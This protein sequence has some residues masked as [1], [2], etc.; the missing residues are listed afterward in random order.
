[1]KENKKG[2]VRETYKMRVCFPKDLSILILVL[3]LQFIIC[4][5]L[6]LYIAL[7]NC[8]CTIYPRSH[9]HTPTAEVSVENSIS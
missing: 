3:L 2:H 6:V 7:L 8:R 1:M 5:I 4:T 9:I